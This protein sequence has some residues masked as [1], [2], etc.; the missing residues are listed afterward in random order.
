MNE[1]INLARKLALFEDRFAPR[2]VATMN[3]YKI[4]VVK[5][6]GAFVWHSHP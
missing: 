1:P 6:E 3:D 5:V 4:A 2:I